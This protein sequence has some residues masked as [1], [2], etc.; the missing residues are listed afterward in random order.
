MYAMIYCVVCQVAT[1]FVLSILVNMPRW[2]QVEI[3]DRYI[4][5]YNA[6]MR[7]VRTTDMGNTMLYEVLYLNVFYT[8][9]VLIL[10]LIV[11]VVL[12]AIILTE[13]QMSKRRMKGNLQGS[14][15]PYIG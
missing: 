3:V 4:A 8:G 7:V 2:F 1:V 5:A 11:L 13:L 9:A 14:S 6:T 12:N 15:V 10:P